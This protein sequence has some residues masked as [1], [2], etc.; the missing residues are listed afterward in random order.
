MHIPRAI[1]FKMFRH[2]ADK[3]G[4]YLLVDMV[5]YSGLIVCNVLVPSLFFFAYADF[6]TSTTHKTLRG[7]E[8]EPYHGTI[9]TTQKKKKINSAIFPGTQGGPLMNIIVQ[10]HRYPS[11]QTRMIS[12]IIPSEV[13]AN[14]QAMARVFKESGY[15][16]LTDGTG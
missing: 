13:V 8:A 9:L 3:V 2:I 7:S 10:R 4:A 14:A 11:K 6:V 5:H 1:D 12:R 16:L 15:K